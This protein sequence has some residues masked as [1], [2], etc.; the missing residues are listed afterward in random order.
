MG[1]MV[2]QQS[3]CFIYKFKYKYNYKN[4]YKYKAE[5][6]EGKKIGKVWGP[7]SLRG[8]TTCETFH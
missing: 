5:K 4:K 3:A 8:E 7:A 2:F 1:A 6:D